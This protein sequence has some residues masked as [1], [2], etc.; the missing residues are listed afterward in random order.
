MFATSKEPGGS[1]SSF[2][3]PRR[4]RRLRNWLLVV[5]GL[6][7][8]AALAAKPAYRKWQSFRRQRADRFAEMGYVAW[9]QGDLRSAEVSFDS[10]RALDPGFIGPE[11]LKGRMFLLSGNRDRGYAVFRELLRAYQGPVRDLVAANYHDAL[12]GTACWEELA[13]LGI[14][15]LARLRNDDPVWIKAAM[16][17]LR[18]APQSL[19]VQDW[20][21]RLTPQ[22]H[23][24]ARNVLAAQLELNGG[25]R[26]GA[27]RRLREIRFPLA[28]RLSLIVADLWLRVGNP[29][30]ARLTLSRIDRVLTPADTAQAAMVL[31]SDDPALAARTVANLCARP[32][33]GEWESRIVLVALSQAMANPS[34]LVAEAFS[35]G[36]E[37]TYGKLG[38]ATLSALW[39]YCELAGADQH[40]LV[41]RE[42]LS[43]RLGGR[44]L[45]R[46]F[47]PLNDN[48]FVVVANAVPLRLDSVYGL[49]DSLRS[50]LAVAPNNA[51]ALPERTQRGSPALP[52]S[53]K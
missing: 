19:R 22:L 47:T 6:E 32:W 4:S 12:L 39:L 29:T 37:P 50:G 28:P 36:L 53:A 48:R 8:L 40:A 38:S 30:E 44:Q 18:L 21:K 42:R 13:A 7:V 33:S 15:Q 20:L 14:E 25:N 31:A 2:P 3:R 24:T 26:A 41:W 35:R 9:R 51:E 17:G 1:R 23:P 16:S 27:T 49:A 5:L 11:L 45:A 10:A 43:Q 46:D 34:K 52:V